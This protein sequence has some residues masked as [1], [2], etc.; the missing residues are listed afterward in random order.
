MI[1][2]AVWEGLL[3]A[4]CV[5]KLGS[6]ALMMSLSLLTGIFPRFFPHLHLLLHIHL[7]LHLDQAQDTLVPA[8]EA[9]AVHEVEEGLAL[10]QEVD[11]MPGDLDHV[12]DETNLLILHAVC[13]TSLAMNMIH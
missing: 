1:F 7:H 6:S 3:D 2:T 9:T 10:S 4:L 11:L 13:L 5:M 12:T 8:L